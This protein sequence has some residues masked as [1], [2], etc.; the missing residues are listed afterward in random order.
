MALA[1]SLANC[2]GWSWSFGKSF[3]PGAIYKIQGTVDSLLR[4]RY[5]AV[6]F[7]DIITRSVASHDW[8]SFRKVSSYLRKFLLEL[9][10]P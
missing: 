1:E 7:C 10:H 6:S 9:P 2:R 8:R 5:I 3:N 4:T